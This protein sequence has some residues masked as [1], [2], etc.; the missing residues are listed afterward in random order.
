MRKFPRSTQTEYLYKQTILVDTL[1]RELLELQ[2]L[3]KKVA[4]AENAMVARQD[5]AIA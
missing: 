3:R 4:L 1:E 5:A 2:S